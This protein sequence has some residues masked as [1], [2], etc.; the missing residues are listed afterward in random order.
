VRDATRGTFAKSP[1]SRLSSS[2]STKTLSAPSRK[3]V[4][5]GAA[6]RTAPVPADL[7]ALEDAVDIDTAQPKDAAHP[8]CGCDRLVVRDYLLEDRSVRLSVHVVQVEHV[9]AHRLRVDDAN[10]GL[11]IAVEICARLVEELP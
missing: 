2:P 7:R 3:T 10:L 6:R 8:C 9:F 5:S 1:A 11:R 4:R